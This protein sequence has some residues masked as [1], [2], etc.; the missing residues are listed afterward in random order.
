MTVGSVVVWDCET[1]KLYDS[2]ALQNV[3][4]Q[5]SCTV[6]KA[7]PLPDKNQ[8]VRNHLFACVFEGL[9]WGNGMQW[10]FCKKALLKL[11]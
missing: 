1:W 10:T 5:A 4:L 6:A 7:N 8:L 3:N 11:I 2:Q 9:L